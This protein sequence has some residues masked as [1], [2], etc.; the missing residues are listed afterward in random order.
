MTDATFQAATPPKDRL[1]S[2][3]AKLRKRYAAEKRFQTY[4]SCLLADFLLPCC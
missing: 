4:G 1:S 2:Q 3:E